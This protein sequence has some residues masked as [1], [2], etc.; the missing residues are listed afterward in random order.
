MRMSQKRKTYISSI[1]AYDK[2]VKKCNFN[3]KTRKQ[4]RNAARKHILEC[5]I[6]KR[7]GKLNKYKPRDKSRPPLGLKNVPACNLSL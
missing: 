7:E 1:D 2:P 5:A 4:Q 3:G 6:I